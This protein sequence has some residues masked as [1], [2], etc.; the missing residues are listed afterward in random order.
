MNKKILTAIVLILTLT[1][2]CFACATTDENVS[3]APGEIKY[4]KFCLWPGLGW[5]KESTIKGVNLGL[6]NY[7]NAYPVSGLEFALLGS[8]TENVRGL[9]LSTLFNNNLEFQGFGMSVFNNAENLSGGAQIGIVNKADNFYS[10]LQ[11]GILNI[12]SG[13]LGVQVGLINIMDN[14]FLPVF[15]FFNFSNN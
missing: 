6:I 5:P 13:T 7:N 15:P 12:G 9:E 8:I 2:S 10:G 11:L 1:A 3:Q 14:G 4:F